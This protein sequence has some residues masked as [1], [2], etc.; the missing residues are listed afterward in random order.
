MNETYMKLIYVSKII[1]FGIKYNFISFIK[2]KEDKI[3][4]L[5]KSWGNEINPA[6]LDNY[7]RSC[8]GS[9]VITYLLGIGDRH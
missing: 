7:I 6:L 3:N 4:T 2:F 8:A 1:S 9:C 5:R